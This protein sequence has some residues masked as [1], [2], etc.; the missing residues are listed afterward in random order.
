MTAT[1]MTLAMKGRKNRFIIEE[2]PYASSIGAIQCRQR[3]GGKL[4]YYYRQAA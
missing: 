4:I 2:E 1:T 3:L